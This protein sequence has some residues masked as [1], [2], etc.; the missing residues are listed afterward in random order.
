[1]PPPDP[2]GRTWDTPAYSKWLADRNKVC[3]EIIRQAL[4]SG[5]V[6]VT[7]GGWTHLYCLW[8]VIRDMQPDGTIVG[9]THF[10]P[11][12]NPLDHVRASLDTCRERRESNEPS[13]H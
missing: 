5:A 2:Q 13:I 4:D 3:A 1:L 7:D 8:G 11:R 10:G 12:D 6:V 9:T